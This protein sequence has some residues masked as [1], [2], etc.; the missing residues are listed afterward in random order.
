LIT[1]FPLKDAAVIVS[2]AGFKKK[3]GKEARKDYTGFSK[4]EGS[5][6]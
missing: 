3:G 4:G 6:K 2:G 1:T 5:K